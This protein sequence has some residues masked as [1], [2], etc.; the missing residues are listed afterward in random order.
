M[1]GGGAV[2]AQP[3]VL[4]SANRMI[5]SRSG[6]YIGC[7]EN[8]N[9][10]AAKIKERYAAD[11]IGTRGYHGPPKLTAGAGPLNSP[12]LPTPTESLGTLLLSPTSATGE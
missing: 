9:S 2:P 10:P 11:R 7:L 12:F 5:S 4:D 8:E 1:Q 6:V 3:K